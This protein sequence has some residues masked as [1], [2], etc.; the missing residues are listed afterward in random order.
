MALLATSICV[1]WTNVRSIFNWFG[2]KR[3]RKAGDE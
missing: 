2:G 1:S 3:F